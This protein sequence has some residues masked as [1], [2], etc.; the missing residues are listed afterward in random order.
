MELIRVESKKVGIRY[1][2]TLAALAFVATITIE[3]RIADIIENK[4]AIPVF[5][6][7]KED[8]SIDFSSF[9]SL[10]LSPKTSF[11]IF[12]VTRR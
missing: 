11:L 9:T 2:T 4:T 6:V 3:R 12:Q 10:I 1:I 5:I 7:V 8:N